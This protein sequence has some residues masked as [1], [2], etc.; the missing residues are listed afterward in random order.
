MGYKNPHDFHHENGKIE[1]PNLTKMHIFQ[2]GGF[3][4]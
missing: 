3:S 1:I 2:L 4:S